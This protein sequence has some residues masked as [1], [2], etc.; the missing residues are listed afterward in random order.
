MPFGT[1]KSNVIIFLVPYP[2]FSSYQKQSVP[3]YIFPWKLFIQLIAPCLN[4]IQ[5][6]YFGTYLELLSKRWSCLTCTDFW[7][8]R[9][10][11][12]SI[13]FMF[14]FY[15][16]RNNHGNIERYGRVVSGVTTMY[17]PRNIKI[18]KRLQWGS[19]HHNY[20]MWC[21]LVEL[22]KT[23]KNVHNILSFPFAKDIVRTIVTY[24]V[25]MFCHSVIIFKKTGIYYKPEIYFS[26]T[27]SINEVFKD[28]D[29]VW[30]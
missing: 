10:T 1:W 27:S 25:R 9:S 24:Y 11:F 21:F 3:L 2:L 4:L 16:T 6:C 7:S 8:A 26:N 19:Y 13:F 17:T 14:G 12:S 28:I 29:E 20:F 5:K 15:F 23:F 22:K 30:L 18:S